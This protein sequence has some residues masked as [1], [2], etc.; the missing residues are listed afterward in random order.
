[1]G[2]AKN[3][4]QVLCAFQMRNKVYPPRVRKFFRGLYATLFLAHHASAKE[5]ERN[6]YYAYRNGYV[7]GASEYGA[8]PQQVEDEIPDLGFNKET[9]D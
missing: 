6:I 4:L 2:K 8:N 3:P 7:L 1:M 5:L 9:K